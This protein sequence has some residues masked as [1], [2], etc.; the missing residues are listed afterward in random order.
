[1]IETYEQSMTCQVCK[2][3]GNMPARSSCDMV[4]AKVC[5]VCKGSGIEKVTVTRM[6]W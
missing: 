5:T 2:G 3:T 4:S 1:M 6:G